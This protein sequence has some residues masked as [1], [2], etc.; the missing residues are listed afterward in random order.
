MTLL[1]IGGGR[2]RD[3][4]AERGQGPVAKTADSGDSASRHDV[5]V[6]PVSACPDAG[7]LRVEEPGGPDPETT[8]PALSLL[9]RVSV[10]LTAVSVVLARVLVMVA[11]RLGHQVWTTGGRTCRTCWLACV[12]ARSTTAPVVRAT[13]E[14]TGRCARSA[15]VAGGSRL[16]SAAI[17]RR[18][19]WPRLSRVRWRAILAAVGALVTWMVV[20]V[21]LFICYLHVSRTSAVTSDGASNALQAWDMLHHNPLL[22]GWELS[23]VSFYTTELPEYALIEAVRGLSVD[24][25]HVASAMTYTLLVLLAALIAKGGATGRQALVR[26]LIAGG[27]MLAPQAGAAVSVLLGSPDHTGSAVPVLLAFLL[28]DRASRRWYMPIAVTVVLGVGLVADQIIVYTGVVPLVAVSLAQAYQRRFADGAR[29]RSLGYE[30][31]L[32]AGAIGAVPAAAMVLGQ[33]NA[34]GGFR[35]WPAPSLLAASGDLPNNL[36]L[37]GHGLLTLFGADFFGQL[38]GSSAVLA[39]VHL[40][41]L[42]LAGWATATALRR[43][44]RNDMVVRVLAV[45]VVVTLAAYM[46]ST[47]VQDLRSTRDIAA[48]LPFGAALAGRVLEG[49]LSRAGMRPALVLVLAIYVISLGQAVTTPPAV[50]PDARLATWLAARHLDYGLVGYWQANVTTL[51]TGGRIRLLSMLAQGTTINA[52]SWEVKTSWYN[53]AR[54]DANFIVLVSAPANFQHYPSM[55]AVRALFG[56][57]LRIY[58]VDE[59]TIM[60]WNKNL[61]VYLSPGRPPLP[62]QVPAVRRTSEPIPVPG[63]S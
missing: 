23:D 19:R 1:R 45:A 61:L 54:H 7:D 25:V 5:G 6:D 13:A 60:V 26:C 4:R 18:L 2:G 41:G 37:T 27:V 49:R 40:I 38:V 55:A 46:L 17:R 10:R 52:G 59:F 21:T 20:G 48:V 16:R 44:R 35:V 62:P 31:S 14:W 11:A 53:A 9:P 56:Q 57:P 8:E 22:R 15:A 58:Y 3:R 63:G 28:V 29:W 12:R 51:G 43:W 24:V 33:I 34:R 50:Q 42:G 30:I 36:A 39:G 47:R 32:A